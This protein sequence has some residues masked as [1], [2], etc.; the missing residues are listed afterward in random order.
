MIVQDMMTE[1]GL[2][3][4]QEVGVE[5]PDLRTWS[6]HE[7]HNPNQVLARDPLEG[8]VCSSGEHNNNHCLEN[9]QQ[10]KHA[11]GQGASVC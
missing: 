10:D 1:S 4:A 5:A 9:Q 11:L 3:G 8:A 7:A 6:G 2:R